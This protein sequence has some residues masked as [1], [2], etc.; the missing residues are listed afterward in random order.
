L[1]NSSYPLD[2]KKKRKKK[3]KKK[4]KRKRRRR[5]SLLHRKVKHQARELVPTLQTGLGFI[6]NIAKRSTI[7]GLPPT[8]PLQREDLDAWQKCYTYHFLKLVF[9]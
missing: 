1:Q 7:G 9:K 5:S 6:K 3:E 8:R 2:I 4:E